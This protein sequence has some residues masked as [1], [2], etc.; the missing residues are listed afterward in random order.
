MGTGWLGRPVVGGLYFYP[1]QGAFLQGLDS[2]I[3]RDQRVAS[4]Q[5][6]AYR[7]DVVA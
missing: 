4:N 1:F 7:Y 3:D 5:I 2:F 6:V